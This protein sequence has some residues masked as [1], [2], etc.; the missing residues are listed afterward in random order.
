MEATYLTSFPLLYYGIYL[1]TYLPF[2]LNT[3]IEFKEKFPHSEEPIRQI[4]IE[5]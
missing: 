4:Y 3:Q 2:Q 5:I 1:F